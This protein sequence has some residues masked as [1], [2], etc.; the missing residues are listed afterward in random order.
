MTAAW[1]ARVFCILILRACKCAR[2]LALGV[3]VR[4]NFPAQ[5]SVGRAAE[6][7]MELRAPRECEPDALDSVGGIQFGSAYPTMQPLFQGASDSL[8]TEL[9]EAGAGRSQGNLADAQ[10]PLPSV[11]CRSA[12]KARLFACRPDWS[13]ARKKGISSNC[14][15]PPDYGKRDTGIQRTASAERRRS[16]SESGH[17]LRTFLEFDCNTMPVR[18]QVRRRKELL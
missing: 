18:A 7:A 8:W 1:E 13:R 16:Y 14:S 15:F 17:V 4:N 2:G 9:N 5:H 12:R 11:R 6:A 10:W 3:T